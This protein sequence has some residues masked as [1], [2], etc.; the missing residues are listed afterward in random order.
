LRLDIAALLI[1]GVAGQAAR[2]LLR[3]G[4]AR[5]DRHAV[6]ALLA[7]PDGVIAGRLQLRLRKPLLRRFELL[8]AGDVRLLF[9]EPLQECRK[10][11]GDAVDVVGGD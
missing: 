4:A 6:P 8:Q 9:F 11:A 2:H 5:Q 3:L 10:P 7:M 1:L